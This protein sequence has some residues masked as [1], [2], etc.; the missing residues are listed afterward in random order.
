MIR[1]II[2]ENLNYL[3]DTGDEKDFSFDSE[4]IESI[5]E[6][7]EDYVNTNYP[8]ID[9]YELDRY[10]EEL[11]FYGISNHLMPSP[12]VSQIIVAPRLNNEV[13]H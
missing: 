1:E 10:F 8:N 13:I 12:F 4:K 9:N 6:A 2:Y 7:I 3:I 11:G 5:Q